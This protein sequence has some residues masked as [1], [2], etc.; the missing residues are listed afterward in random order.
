[1]GTS[2]PELQAIAIEIFEVCM[3]FDVAM[4]IEWLPRSQNDK[5]HHRSRILEESGVRGD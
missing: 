1:M 5:A 4:E 3:S 2:R